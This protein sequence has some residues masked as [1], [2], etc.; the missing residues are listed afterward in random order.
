MLYHV[1]RW[2]PGRTGGAKDFS[3]RRPDGQGGWINNMQG[4]PRVLWRLPEVLATVAAGDVVYVVEGEKAC[5]ALV[6]LGVCATTKSG[7]TV[8]AAKEKFSR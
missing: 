8:L 6:E 5:V 2:E 4:V 7:A 1:Q 3:Q